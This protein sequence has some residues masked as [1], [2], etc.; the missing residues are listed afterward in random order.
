MDIFSLNCL[1]KL[2]KLHFMKTHFPYNGDKTYTVDIQKKY[3]YIAV[4]SMESKSQQT[5]H[6][7]SDSG[8]HLFIADT[9]YVFTHMVCKSCPSGS[10]ACHRGPRL[11]DTKW[12]S[13]K[14]KSRSQLPQ[15]CTGLACELTYFSM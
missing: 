4:R 13:A 3:I 6:R 9:S 11:A 5:P 8:C 15:L 2:H 10:A 1:R 7:N 14:R 12:I